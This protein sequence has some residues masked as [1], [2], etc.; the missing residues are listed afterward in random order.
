MARIYDF[1]G[2]KKAAAAAPAAPA[3]P[4]SRLKKVLPAISRA[5]W[6]ATVLMWPVLRWVVSIDVF[7]RLLVMLYQWDAPESYAGWTFL[8]HAAVLVA[9]TCYVSIYKPPGIER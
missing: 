8:L 1:P 5:A 7:I 2:V 6:T 4:A 3:A 9:L